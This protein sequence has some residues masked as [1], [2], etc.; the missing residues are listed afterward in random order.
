[1]YVCSAVNADAHDDVIKWEHF[2]RYWPFVRGIHWLP[3][4]SPHKGQ[5]RGAL[6]FSLICAWI[7]GW[8]NNREACDSRRYR[9]H[10]DV[11]VISSDP[12]IQ[13]ERP[14]WHSG[15]CSNPPVSVCGYANEAVLKRTKLYSLDIYNLYNIE[16]CI[17]MK[18][19]YETFM[20]PDRLY[21]S[22]MCFIF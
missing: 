19:V 15:A 9:S 11:T 16:W 2:Q 14:P 6:M 20:G 10:Y 22:H 21:F 17:G 18:Y 8:V 3:V 5:W 13:G 7:Y 4:N 1:M 12:V